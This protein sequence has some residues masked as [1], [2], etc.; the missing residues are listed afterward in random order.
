MPTLELTEHRDAS[1]Q[2]SQPEE[3][4]ADENNP[5]ESGPQ[6]S[7]AA[8]ATRVAFI[9]LAVAAL[10]AWLW[11]DVIKY[12]VTAKRFGVV[13]P[14]RVY[15]SGQISK[16]MIG[17]TLDKYAITTVVDLQGRDPNDRFQ[18]KEIETVLGRG[19]ELRRFPLGGDGTGDVRMYADAIQ[20]IAGCE[21]TGRPVLVHCAAGTQRT[22]GVVACYRVLVRNESPQDAYEE[23]KR[24]D[25]D[26]HDDAVLLEF[27]NGHMRELAELLVARGVISRLPG[28]IP[29]IAP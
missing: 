25:W 2:T 1:G 23:L 15:R 22:G 9:T 20:V 19:L 13:V 21:R 4:R 5:E 16:W 18:E 28:H 12:R 29:V 3:S 6:L 24:Y 10:G 27:V 11:H 14:G 8:R 26:P 17:P 7:R